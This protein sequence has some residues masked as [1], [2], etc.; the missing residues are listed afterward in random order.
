MA[1]TEPLYDLVLLLDTSAPEDS[2]RRSSPTSS[3][4]LVRRRRS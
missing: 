2:A 3:G 4:D 1:C